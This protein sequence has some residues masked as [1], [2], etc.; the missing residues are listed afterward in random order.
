MNIH[1]VWGCLLTPENVSE[2][3]E[4][5]AIRYHAWVAA[6]QVV[7]ENPSVF[8]YLSLQCVSV[9]MTLSNREC[10]LKQVR[11]SPAYVTYALRRFVGTFCH[12]QSDA[13]GGTA[14]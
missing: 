3:V 11:N 13:D 1:D 4:T 14:C 6:L 12:V 10:C 8:G 7:K 5:D 9:F 2:R